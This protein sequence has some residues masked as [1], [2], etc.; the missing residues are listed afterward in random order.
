MPFYVYKGIL[1]SSALLRVQRVHTYTL[2]LHYLFYFRE[3]IILFLKEW[4]VCKPNKYYRFTLLKLFEAIFVKPVSITNI[5]LLS[6][7]S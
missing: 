2:D 4:F 1:I 3:M 5:L 7:N 6:I